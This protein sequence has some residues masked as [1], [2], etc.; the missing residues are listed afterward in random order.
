MKLTEDMI[1][2]R[3]GVLFCLDYLVHHM[4]DEEHQI[5]WLEDGIPDDIWSNA[6]PLTDE[7]LKPYKDFALDEFGEIDFNTF[8]KIAVRLIYR[9]CF[10]VHYER[11]GLT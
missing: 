8:V 7:Q 10:K 11:D 3:A 1:K 9:E 4:S 5:E 2:S 6:I